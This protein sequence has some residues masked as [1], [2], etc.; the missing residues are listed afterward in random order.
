MGRLAV[1]VGVAL[2]IT[3]A[4]V[5]RIFT[6]TLS[7]NLGPSANEEAFQSLRGT[8]NAISESPPSLPL[9][10]PTPL[11]TLQ[12][13]PPPQTQPP[14]PLSEQP[15][16]VREKLLQAPSQST[17]TSQPQQQSLPSKLPPSAVQPSAQSQD[18]ATYLNVMKSIC[19]IT[20]VHNLT[21]DS[22]RQWPQPV[23]DELVL[24]IQLGSE[25]SYAKWGRA[26]PSA[27]RP[28]LEPE[29]NN[30]KNKNN[31][32][33]TNNTNNNNNNSNTNNNSNN[34]SN[35]NNKLCSDPRWRQLFTGALLQSPA[36]VVDVLSGFQGGAEVGL[37]ELRVH[38]YSGLAMT[39]LGEG[40]FNH[41]GDAKRLAFPA[42]EE[43]FF[44]P[45]E[46]SDLQLEYIVLDDSSQPACTKYQSRVQELRGRRGPRQQD[47]WPLQNSQRSC[48]WQELIHRKPNLPDDA[49]VIFSDLDEIPQVEL[50]AALKF[51]ERLPI[52]LDKQPLN[53]MHH[54]VYYNLRTA[55]TECK[56][57]PS[58]AQGSVNLRRFISAADGP[59]LGYPNSITV[60]GGV[61]LTYLGSTLQLM[62]KG[63]NHAEGGGL[64]GMDIPGPKGEQRRI[65]GA[66]E[67]EAAP[68]MRLVRDDPTWVARQWEHR[69]G[70]LPKGPPS[71]ADLARCSIPHFLRANPQRYH[72]FWGTPPT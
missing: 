57:A 54:S 49:I 2:A 45:T 50:V 55:I 62:Y 8:I 71:E 7:Q 61:H 39:V 11:S 4:S 30:N 43:A 41:R 63:I 42:F 18:E 22:A 21:V 25:A 31:N 60:E 5:F 52:V 35:H 37:L 32:N 27:Q 14:Q 13:S 66:T 48:I 15:P 59:A 46:A 70:E 47:E 26:P 24:A 19:N 58:H 23:R 10:S 34:N 16:A 1:F 3:G 20:Q 33:D 17:S 6:A 28:K 12:T 53:L 56:G 51:C 69:H 9:S 68:L 38:E 29:E 67:A 64:L 44:K 65:C 72:D 40:R 36:V